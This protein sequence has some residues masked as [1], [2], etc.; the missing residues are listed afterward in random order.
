MQCQAAGGRPSIAD[1]EWR[2]AV[3]ESR[4]ALLYMAMLNMA[5]PHAVDADLKALLVS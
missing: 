2:H 4:H 3:D 1:H 5:F